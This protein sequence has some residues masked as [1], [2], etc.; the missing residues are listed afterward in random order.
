MKHVGFSCDSC[1]TKLGLVLGTE[2][3]VLT[4]GRHE[5]V[6]R[7]VDLCATCKNRVEHA[8][9]IKWAGVAGRAE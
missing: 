9:G 5:C 6:T 4:Y 3:W 7:S 8:L 1:A 2:H